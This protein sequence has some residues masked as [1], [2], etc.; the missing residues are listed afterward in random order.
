MSKLP[1]VRPVSAYCIWIVTR[2]SAGS[3]FRVWRGPRTVEALTRC[4]ATLDALKFP[5]WLEVESAA[6]G[7][8]MMTIG[9]LASLGILTTEEYPIRR[10]RRHIESVTRTSRRR[11]APMW[12]ID[13]GET[14]VRLGAAAAAKFVRLTHGKDRDEN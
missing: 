14:A 6:C 5:S 12:L 8:V 1:D 10:A 4:I 2:T 11:R 13:A 7:P 3:N 9:E